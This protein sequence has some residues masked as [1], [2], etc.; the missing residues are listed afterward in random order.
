VSQSVV[1][2]A[3]SP[4]GDG[5]NWKRLSTSFVVW[6]TVFDLVAIVV[7]LVIMVILALR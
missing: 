6:S 7:F 4:G 2:Q 3:L 1:S 5:M